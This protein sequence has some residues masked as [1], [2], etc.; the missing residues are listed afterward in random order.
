MNKHLIFLF[1]IVN[2]NLFAQN[3]F[4]VDNIVYQFDQDIDEYNLHEISIEDF[5]KLYPNTFYYRSSTFESYRNIK[6][7]ENNQFAMAIYEYNWYEVKT[8]VFTKENTFINDNIFIGNSYSNIKAEEDEP[9]SE[10]GLNQYFKVMHFGK[11]YKGYHSSIFDMT[12]F[13]SQ[14]RL[15]YRIQI[16]IVTKSLRDENFLT[17]IFNEWRAPKSSFG[18]VFLSLQKDYSFILRN[19]LNLFEEG[20][21]SIIYNDEIPVFKILTANGNTINYEYPIYKVG[22]NMYCIYINQLFYLYPFPS[23][24]KE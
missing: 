20:T 18:I 19:E 17:I 3:V 10:Y 9:A 2:I 1:C 22:N 7:Y 8:F 15:L 6:T 16:N 5:E 21:F 23:W 12:L 24:I 4:K 14:D 13:F 11:M